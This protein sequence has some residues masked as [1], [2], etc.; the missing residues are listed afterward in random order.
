MK[1]TEGPLNKRNT[2][3]TD[4]KNIRAKSQFLGGGPGLIFTQPFTK[5]EN[6]LLICLFLHIIEEGAGP[7][8]NFQVG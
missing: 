8:I 3:A 7:L 5:H 6:W 4:A 1:L 2:P